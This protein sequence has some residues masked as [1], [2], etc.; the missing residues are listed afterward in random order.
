MKQIDTLVEDIYEIFSSDFSP[1]PE[2]IQRFGQQLASHLATR[3]GEQR[4]GGYLRLSNIGT[5]CERKLWYS[6]N[7]PDEGEALSPAT[8][9]KFLFGDILEEL[10]LFLA[11]QAGHE[12]A[13]EQ[14]E[15]EINGIKGHRDA[16]ID[17]TLIDVKSAS[18]RSYDKFASGRLAG[19]DPFGYRDQLG[20][21]AYGS[22]E[23]PLLR[24]REVAG[25]LVI[26]KQLGKICLD[27]HP[28]TDVPYDQVVESKKEVVS[29]PEPPA[30]P[31]VPVPDGKSGNMK[32]GTVCSYC[33]FK[34]LCWSD[35]NNGQGLRTFIY[36]SGPRYLTTVA[37]QPDVV[38]VDQRNKPKE[39]AYV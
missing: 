32:L 30:R 12:V 14:D 9:I 4:Q 19:D 21:Y 17:G 18:S 27:K 8:R 33:S 26:D 38:E 23:D 11:E 22:R 29:L 6:V 1:T 3:I 28:I 5:P 34:H 25:F 15:I 2:A 13:G 10:L 36:A 20:A 7:T 24:D 31:Y 39:I 16:I 37:R 35:S